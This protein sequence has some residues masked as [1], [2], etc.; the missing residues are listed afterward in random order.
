MNGSLLGGQGRKGIPRSNITCKH[1][2]AF[3]NIVLLKTVTDLLW[4]SCKGNQRAMKLERQE[5]TGD[6]GRL[7]WLM[8]KS[9]NLILHTVG[10]HL[11]GFKQGSNRIKL[12]FRNLKM[13]VGLE[14]E[15]GRIQEEA[16]RQLRNPGE[17]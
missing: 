14:G 8:M 6:L 2:E 5:V 15:C 9:L 13:E 10:R 16:E 4:Q 17:K 7:W 1:T 12:C 11:K 3:N